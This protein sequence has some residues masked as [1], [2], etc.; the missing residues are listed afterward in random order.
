MTYEMR[1][2]LAR[3]IGLQVEEV[4]ENGIVT[5]AEIRPEFCNA[6]GFAHG[7]YV[8]TLGHLT[9]QLAAELC[10]KRNCKVVDAFSQYLSS[11]KVSPARVETELLRS[12]KELLMYRVRI[13]DGM[14]RLCF[15]QTVTLRENVHEP[16]DYT[17]HEQTIFADR[18]GEIDP[19]TGVNY[20][21]VSPFFA[22]EC[23]VHMIGRGESGLIYGADLYP[24]NVDAFGAAHGG[25]IYTACDACSGG[26]VAMLLEK[27]PVTVASEISFLRSATVGPIHVEAKLVR[28]GKQ[29]MFYDMDITD[30]RGVL[31][32]TAQFTLQGVDYKATESLGTQYRN[33][34]FK[35]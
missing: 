9:A 20:P 29:L 28:N 25:M 32:A 12:R 33:K 7:G 3:K 30:G 19:V 31:V 13:L 18:P 5:T 4:R 2:P 23:H 26:S 11:L 1:D 24:D 27:R 17:P 21:R 6:Y 8:Y 14:G 22:A 35:D 16:A 34:A 10:E 15:N